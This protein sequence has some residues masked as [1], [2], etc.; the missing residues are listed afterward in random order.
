MLNL[1]MRR[2]FVYGCCICAS[3]PILFLLFESPLLNRTEAGEPPEN[4]KE[5]LEN[6]ADASQNSAP[7]FSP[8][9]PL[10]MPVRSGIN[11]WVLPMPNPRDGWLI[12]V[13]SVAVQ[14]SAKPL[15]LRFKTASDTSGKLENFGLE[16][17]KPI[18]VIP[19]RQSLKHTVARPR[20]Q[21]ELAAAEPI[22]QAS[23][24]VIQTRTGPSDDLSLYEKIQTKI[25]AVGERVVIYVDDR[26]HDIVTNDVLKAIVN[27]M[28]HDIPEKVIPRIG[29]ALDTDGNG[30]MNVVL[31]Q[32][33]NRMADGTV[34][35]DGFVRPSDFDASGSLPLSHARDMIYLNSRVTDID[36]LKS[37]LAHEFTH[38]VTASARLSV[39]G[40]TA[41][42]EESWL[43]EGIAHLSE[44]WIDGSWGNLDYRVSAF[45]QHP[46]NH[47]LIV[48]DQVGLGSSRAHGHRGASFLFLKWCESVFGSDL[49]SRLIYS[50]LSGVRN[51]EAATGQG[52]ED[53][54]R[55]WSV[56]LMRDQE[57]ARSFDEIRSNALLDD[58]LA[59][60]PSRTIVDSET[61]P[62][63]FHWAPK[64]T[65]QRF[66]EIE[67]RGHEGLG[68]SVEIQIE[69]ESGSNVQ[70]TAIPI[71]NRHSGLE[72]TVLESPVQS[73]SNVEREVRLVVRNRDTERPL[74]LQAASWESVSP[75][76]DAQAIRQNRGFFD[77]LTVARWL[78]TNKLLPG[79]S[80]VSQPISLK[81]TGPILTS[82]KIAWKMVAHDESGKPLFGSTQTELHR[83][84]KEVP[85][86]AGTSLLEELEVLRR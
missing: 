25:A 45:Y 71:R 47:Q 85:R 35:L 80:L 52:F 27:I 22:G 54:F 53:L 79:Q 62:A 64:G 55:A 41:A 8:G 42:E 50:N 37:L 56:A 49:A 19:Y 4:R 38:A 20:N 68:Q 36:Y 9:Q 82:G 12:S 73:I 67:N 39:A 32:T 75:W 60:I 44:R 18:T 21:S 70:L 15:A 63:V 84:Q 11:R 58:W 72:I 5:I 30:R 83:Q 6:S 1:R 57:C 78:G 7:V 74:K 43:E 65:S 33:L 2:L 3:F 26:D 66:F 17:L 23:S 13:G 14:D 77:L 81:L 48:N 31:T 40:L 10:V 16:P 76:A 86:F 24:F 61:E 51:L 59:G 69:V 28:D 34:A 29:E 46:E